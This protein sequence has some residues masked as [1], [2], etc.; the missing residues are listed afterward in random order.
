MG[1]INLLRQG[2]WQRDPKGQNLPGFDKNGDDEVDGL[3]QRLFPRNEDGDKELTFGV[4]HSSR[5][6]FSH[7]FMW[8]LGENTLR[9]LMQYP[10]ALVKKVKTAQ[11][12]VNNSSSLGISEIS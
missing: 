12:I 5:I 4:T 8:V 9:S 11:V 6:D 10:A 1:T 3:S 2:S 7:L